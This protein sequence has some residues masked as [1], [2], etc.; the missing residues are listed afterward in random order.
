MTSNGI[1]LG[2]NGYYIQQ[3]LNKSNGTIDF[4]SEGYVDLTLTNNAK[5]LQENFRNQL[6]AIW[7]KQGIFNKDLSEKINYQDLTLSDNARKLQEH[8]KKV[9]EDRWNRKLSKRK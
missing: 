8:D 2:Y 7:Q 9:L 6:S 3:P 1:N 5:E 4:R